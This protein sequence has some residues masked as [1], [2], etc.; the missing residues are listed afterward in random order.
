ML[1]NNNYIT[2]NKFPLKSPQATEELLF[3]Y[4]LP[5]PYSIISINITKYTLSAFLTM[6]NKL[7]SSLEKEIVKKIFII[8]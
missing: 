4:F 8:M 3:Y 7:Y 6:S 1:N 2:L 5:I